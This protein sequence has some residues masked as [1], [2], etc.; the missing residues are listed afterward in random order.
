[1]SDKVVMEDK[2]PMCVVY[3]K[4]ATMGTLILGNGGLESISGRPRYCRSLSERTPSSHS[5]TSLKGAGDPEL[6][7]SKVGRNGRQRLR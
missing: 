1:M 5:L 3:G 6:G 2:D 7:G 4:K